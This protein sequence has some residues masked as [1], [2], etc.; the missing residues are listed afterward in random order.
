MP[1]L[2]ERVL[3]EL[4]ANVQNALE[5][6]TKTDMKEIKGLEERLFGLEQLMYGSKR[7]VQEQSDLATVSAFLI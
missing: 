4:R 2:D 5:A 7:I 3:E 6:A 1:Q